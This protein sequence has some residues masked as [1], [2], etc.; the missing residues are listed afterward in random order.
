MKNFRNYVAFLAIFAMIFT[1]CSKEENGAV[2]PGDDQNTVQLILG[3][4]LSD[5]TSKQESPG[6]CRDEVP[7]YVA[8]GITDASGNYVGV[9]GGTSEL[10]WI[11]IGLKNNNGNWETEYS[12]EL[13]LPAGSYDL[14]HFVVY[15]ASGEVL[16]VAPRTEGTFA[17]YVS[18]PLPQPIALA[19]GTKPYIEVDVLCYF[20]REEAAYG[21]VFFDINLTEVENS[22]CVFV[23]YCD[24]ET[25]R[26]YPANFMVEVWRDGFGGSD[27]I[28]LNN[29][30]NSITMAGDYPSASVLCFALPDLGD[31]TVYARVT[32][33]DHNWL[34]YT[35]NS[36]DYYEF[37]IT[38][39]D[40][41]GQL[42]MTPSYHHVRVNCDETT[43]PP[44]GCLPAVDPG[45]DTMTFNETVDI[46]GFPTG[47]DPFYPLFI[48]GEEVGQ[49]I[50]DL[51]AAGADRIS[52]IVD[53][54][55][56]YTATAAEVSLPAF[57]NT[58]ICISNI[59]E[60]DFTAVYIVD[61]T[62]FSGGINYPVDVEFAANV[63]PP[64]GT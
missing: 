33:Q 53:L 25:G 42:N 36:N 2:I 11:E 21:Y 27:E 54:F 47:T 23:N 30:M 43:E 22:Y 50:F 41:E 18:S 13:E 6:E 14:Q 26:E 44:V 20:A 10:H 52:V 5:F 15:D 1:S 58:Q 56:G 57:V 38:Q 8:V 45:C 37:E 61:E 4:T 9:G 35:S 16:W 31:A 28:T 29:N 7:S 12:S 17:D 39:A 40:I 46:S 63:C 48:E 62:E 51:E 34:P 55:E 24:D 60:N 19:P 32:V 64:A 59:N 49:I 3:A